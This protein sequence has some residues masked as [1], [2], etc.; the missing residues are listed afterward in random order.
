M[1][2]RIY[3]PLLVSWDLAAPKSL[4]AFFKSFA[5]SAASPFCA[6]SRAQSPRRATHSRF[7]ARAASSAFCASETSAVESKDYK[8]AQDV[9]HKIAFLHSII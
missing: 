3:K 5:W 6:T 9:N 1:P 8:A 4:T 7:C 2:P